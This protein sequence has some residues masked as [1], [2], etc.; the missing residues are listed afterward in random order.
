MAKQLPFNKIKLPPSSS[1]LVDRMQ[2]RLILNC[3][4]MTICRMEQDGKLTPVKLRDGTTSKIFYTKEEVY[5]KAGVK[6]PAIT[7]AA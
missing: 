5:A 2:A 6:M 1:L 4:Y 3:C 7:N